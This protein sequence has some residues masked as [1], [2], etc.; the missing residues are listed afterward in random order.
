MFAKNTVTQSMIDAVNAVISEEKKRMI[1]DAEVDETGF[2]KAAH[3]AKRANQSHFEFQGKKYPVTAKSHKEAMEMEEGWDDMLKSVKDKAGPQPSGGS[4]VKQ[5]SR[6]GGSKQK[7]KPEHDEPKDK[8]KKEE[9]D[10]V[11][12]DQAKKIAD[13]EA[14]KEVSHHNTSMHKGQKNTVKKEE[15]T[16]KSRLIEGIK[17]KSKEEDM[18]PEEKMSDAQMKKREK[19]VMSMKSNEAGFKKKYGKNW[20]SVMYATATKQ[21]MAEELVRDEE[22]LEEDLKDTAKKVGRKILKTLGHGSDADMRKDLQRK[23]GMKQTG[24]KPTNEEKDDKETPPWDTDKKGA[25][26]FKKPHNP[27][28]TGMDS[29]RSLAQKGMKKPTKEEIELTEGHHMH[30]H[31]VHFSCPMTGEW[32]GKMIYNADHDNEAVEMAQDM[33]KKQGLKVMKVS[34]NNV[35]MSDKTMGEEVVYEASVITHNAS[36]D[37]DMATDMLSGRVQGTAKSNSFKNWKVK[38]E[39]D[40]IKRPEVETASKDSTKARASIEQHD[41][42]DVTPH[43]DPKYAKP[44]EGS[45][46][47]ETV[48]EHK[49]NEMDND[50]FVQNANTTSSPAIKKTP[51]DHVKKITKEAMKKVKTEMLGKAPGN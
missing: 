47:E 41:N 5:G 18:F 3:A 43:L 44:F 15:F 46:A 19:I 21:A 33:A 51:M 6:Y 27:N 10:C 42:K 28:R 25:S 31:T 48:L 1:T 45:F 39:G 12:P 37:S 4:G 32:K 30:T 40:G 26:P 11:T 24:K 34:K 8:M 9:A 17:Q 49:G 22:E 50:P 36:P 7:D 14:K 13:K 23:M 16:L 29:A 35:I 20:K 38:I 2:H